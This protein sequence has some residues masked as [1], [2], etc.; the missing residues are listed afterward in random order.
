MSS[1]SMR[2][3]TLIE[4]YSGWSD[5]YIQQAI[6]NATNIEYTYTVDFGDN[7]VPPAGHQL[8]RNNTIVL[9]PSGC[10]QGD[11]WNCTAAC[12]D[13]E[14]GPSITWS[15]PNSPY[16][17]QNCLV[18]PIIAT[19]AAQ[20]W[21]EEKPP[22]LLKK[23]GIFANLSLPIETT[24]AEVDYH[25]AWP[26]IRNCMQKFCLLLHDGD[27]QRDRCSFGSP[28]LATDYAMGPSS[29]LWSPKLVRTI[30]TSGF[31]NAHVDF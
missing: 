21:L 7:L 11:I 12:L 19:A 5:Y 20:G 30:L 28:A 8:K 27:G 2:H 25:H 13:E 29:S 23:Y 3:L 6:N 26:V 24:N 22:G 9:H 15:G 1:D 4:E 10:Q 18:Y 17:I 16:T 31:V 14:Q